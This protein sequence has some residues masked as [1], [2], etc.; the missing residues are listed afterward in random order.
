VH[1]YTF[2]ISPQSKWCHLISKIL[3][4]SAHL[5]CAFHFAQRSSD[6]CA[7]WQIGHVSARTTPRL[8]QC[9]VIECMGHTY[10][11]EQAIQVECSSSASYW[12]VYSHLGRQARERERDRRSASLLVSDVL[13][14]D[15][16]ART[17]VDCCVL[18]YCKLHLRYSKNFK[19][20]N[21]FFGC[22]LF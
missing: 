4:F 16:G 10:V 17:A 9:N 13:L 18:L 12:D 8:A 22:F 21:P 6:S 14:G 7:V 20:R 5:L 19:K 2:L 3:L 15:V 11:T 1:V